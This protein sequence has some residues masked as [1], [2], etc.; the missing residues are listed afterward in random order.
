MR[1]TFPT[2]FLCGVGAGLGRDDGGTAGVQRRYS[3]GTAGLVRHFIYIPAVP[4]L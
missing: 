2:L 4:P 1:E 3:G